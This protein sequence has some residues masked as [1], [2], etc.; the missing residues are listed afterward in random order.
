[1]PPTALTIARR[2]ASQLRQA[3]AQ[4]FIIGALDWSHKAPQT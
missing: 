1:L 2:D 4:L 3:L